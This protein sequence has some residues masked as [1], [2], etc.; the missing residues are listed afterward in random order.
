MTK[1]LKYNIA[2]L[3]GMLAFSKPAVRSK[4]K[5]LVDLYKDRKISNVTTATKMADKLRTTTPKTEKR[6]FKQYEKLVSKYENNEP[7]A[8]RMQKAKEVRKEKGYKYILNYAAGT[9]V[10]MVDK[11]L[12]ITTT[13]VELLN[14]KEE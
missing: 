1:A 5:T 14:N 9:G 4:V 10:L 11:N 8:V 12:D 3:E 7:L 13:V 6:V 2:F